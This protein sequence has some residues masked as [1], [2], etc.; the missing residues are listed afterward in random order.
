MYYLTKDFLQ[1]RDRQRTW[2][3][4]SQEG[5][6]GPC[7]VIAHARMLSCFSCVQGF[8]TPWALNCQ[9]P[10]C[11]GFSKQEY[12]SGLP[13]PPPGDLTLVSSITC[14][15]G[16]GFTTEPPGKP[17]VT[18]YK[19]PIIICVKRAKILLETQGRASKSATGNQR[20]LLGGHDP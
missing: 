1:E 11:M 13:S 5:S 4:L 2:W 15:A 10:L 17:R 19:L 16:R 6:I 3:P 9:T 8:T 18:V 7:L 12:W 20:R 14:S